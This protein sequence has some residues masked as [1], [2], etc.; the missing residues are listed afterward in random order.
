MALDVALYLNYW[1]LRDYI[2]NLAAVYFER[3]YFERLHVGRDLEPCDWDGDPC[4]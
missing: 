2:P 3:L 1:Y 4:S